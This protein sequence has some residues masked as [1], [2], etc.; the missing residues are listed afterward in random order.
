E[1]RLE[2]SGYELLIQPAKPEA[3]LPFTVELI[4]SSPFKPSLAVLRATSMDMGSVPV[5][6]EPLNNNSTH[7]RA[8]VLVGSCGDPQMQ[9]QLEVPVR[10]I[11]ENHQPME[12]PML[13]EFPL[14][15]LN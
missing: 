3:E 11:S 10:L 5:T 2:Q 15:T 13:I 14:T 8:T 6:W 9:W 1:L 4:S 7:W 12:A